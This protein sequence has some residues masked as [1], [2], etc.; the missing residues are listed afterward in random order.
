ML[1]RDAV[2]MNKQEW[3]SRR[4]SGRRRGISSERFSSRNVINPRRN[5]RRQRY[6]VEWGVGISAAAAII[7]TSG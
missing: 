2:R 6:T 1:R 5:V 3:I 7:G 4:R